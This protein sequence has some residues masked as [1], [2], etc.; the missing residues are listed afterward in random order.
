[1]RYSL[2]NFRLVFMFSNLN[3]LN[4][5]IFNIYNVLTIL[6]FSY[7]ICKLQDPIFILSY[8]INIDLIKLIREFLIAIG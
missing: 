6:A 5:T 8:S 4:R 2:L 1:M 3:I 7:I